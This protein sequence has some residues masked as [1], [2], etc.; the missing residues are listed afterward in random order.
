M[1]LA[2]IFSDFR[3]FHFLKTKVDFFIAGIF[4]GFSF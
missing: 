3:F 2:Y 1:D 4:L